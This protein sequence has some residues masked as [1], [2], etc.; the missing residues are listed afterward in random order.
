MGMGTSDVAEIPVVCCDH[1]AAIVHE[2]AWSQASLI[3]KGTVIVWNWRTGNQVVVFVSSRLSD[4][5]TS[6]IHQSCR[7]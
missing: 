7:F 3:I 4:V 2:H 6:H 1:L 5:L